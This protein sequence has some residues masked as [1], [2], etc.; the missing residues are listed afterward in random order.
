MDPTVRDKNVA[1]TIIP[2]ANGKQAT[3]SMV[4][5]RAG[6][7][8]PHHAHGFQQLLAAVSSAILLTTVSDTAVLQ[9]LCVS[10]LR[11]VRAQKQKTCF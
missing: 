8:P 11:A 2:P 9:F 5:L 6:P 1:T 7:R 10:R 4:C 3:L